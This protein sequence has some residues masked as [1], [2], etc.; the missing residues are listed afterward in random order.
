MP[1]QAQALRQTMANG[2]W[3]SLGR[4]VKDFKQFWRF[5]N[6]IGDPE[7]SCPGCRTPDA[8]PFCG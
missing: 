1:A 7:K 6:R 8:P 5:L 2:G 4:E 3:D